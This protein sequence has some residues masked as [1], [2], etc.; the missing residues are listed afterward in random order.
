MPRTR[1]SVGCSAMVRTRPSPM[2]CATSQMMSIGVGNVEAFAGDADGGVDDRDLPLGKLN[3][4][5]GSGHL[6]HFSYDSIG[7]RALPYIFV[8]SRAA[9]PLTISII[10]LVMLAWRTRFMFS[11]S[12]S[13]TSAAF[14]WRRPWPSCARR[15]RRPPIRASRGRLRL[16]V[17]RQQRCQQFAPAAARRCSRPA[18]RLRAFNGQNAR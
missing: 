5:G 11:V 6:D 7:A 4:D 14:E 16:D 12:L 1:P 15:V 3:V 10:S 18:R 2:C 9:A 17:A 8:Y 13:I